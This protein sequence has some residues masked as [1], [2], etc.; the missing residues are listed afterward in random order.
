MERAESLRVGDNEPT[1]RPTQ[2]NAAAFY[3]PVIGY[4]TKRS[5]YSNLNVSSLKWMFR[6]ANL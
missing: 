5:T 3:V 2:V 4:V 1:D 6:D